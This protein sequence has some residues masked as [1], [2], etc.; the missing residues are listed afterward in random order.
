MPPTRCGR[1]GTGRPPPPAAP[2]TTRVGR[3]ACPRRAAHKPPRPAPARPRAFPSPSIPLPRCGA[4]VDWASKLRIADYG[5]VNMYFN[6]P[7]RSLEEVHKV[8]GRRRECRGAGEVPQDG[9]EPTSMD[10]FPALMQLPAC[11]AGPLPALQACLP[12]P[13]ACLP[14]APEMNSPMPCPPGCRRSTPRSCR[15]APSPSP[16]AAPTSTATP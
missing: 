11:L 4:G 3:R 16:W 8:G 5:N 14:G 15:R 10:G 7:E 9:L 1:C 12:C 2:T 13:P 6:Q